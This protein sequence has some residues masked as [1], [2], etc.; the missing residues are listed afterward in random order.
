M[1]RDDPLQ[2]WPLSLLYFSS[3]QFWFYSL[4]EHVPHVYIF[5]MSYKFLL[6]SHVFYMFS[7]LTCLV[8]AIYIEFSAESIL[9]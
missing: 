7:C 6:I 8:S 1:L 5:Y 9:R 4:L 3:M 2:L